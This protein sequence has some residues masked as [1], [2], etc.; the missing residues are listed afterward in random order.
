MELI[1]WRLLGLGWVT[2]PQLQD[3]LEQQPQ[4]AQELHQQ[5]TRVQGSDLLPDR[6]VQLVARAFGDDKLNLQAA[7]K[8]LGVEATEAT[9]LLSQFRYD[10]S[11]DPQIPGAADAPKH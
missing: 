6:F 4:F 2:A 9:R 1:L 7:T 3:F 5:P 11:T 10:D 8:L